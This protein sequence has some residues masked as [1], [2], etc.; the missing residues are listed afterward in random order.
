MGTLALGCTFNVVNLALVELGVVN[1]DDAVVL[2][3]VLGLSAFTIFEEDALISGIFLPRPEIFINIEV[4]LEL[5]LAAE[6]EAPLALNC[7]KER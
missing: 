7:L 6:T 5:G 4:G 3:A 1:F 2:K